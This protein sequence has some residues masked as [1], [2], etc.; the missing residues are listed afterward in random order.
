[1]NA[2]SDLGAILTLLIFVVMIFG[3]LFLP[4]IIARYRK[5]NN[6]GAIFVTNLIGMFFFGI[7]WIVALIW[8]L[9]DNVEI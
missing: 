6:L 1:M 2:L 8:S 3:G 4:T 9:T 5:H 7:G